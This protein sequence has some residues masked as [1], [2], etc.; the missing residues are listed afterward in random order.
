[1]PLTDVTIRNAKP[2][3]KS[4]RLFDSGGLY[5]EVSPAGG[6]WWRLKYR[7]AGKEKRLSLGVYPDVSLREVRERRDAARK[8]LADGID[9]SE[10]RKAKK[11]ALADK[12]ANSFELVTREWFEKIPRPGLPIIA[13][14]SS[15]VSNA[16]FSRGSAG[17]RCRRSDRTGTARSDPT[18]RSPR[19]IG[20]GPPCA[21]HLR[22]DIPLWRSNGAGDPRSFRRF[23]R[24]LAPG[25][26]GTFCCY[27]R[28]ETAR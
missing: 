5:L 24:R 22:P 4:V 1:M 6:K 9:P 28:T 21:R 15:G 17:D 10:D 20:D 14:A 23:A 13:S 18:G 12:A 16:T 19:R 2:D 3:G 11:L 7:I 25:E 27:H 8:L 26:G